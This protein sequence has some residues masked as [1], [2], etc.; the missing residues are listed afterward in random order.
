MCLPVPLPARSASML[1]PHGMRPCDMHARADTPSDYPH[2]L[3]IDV[4]RMGPKG[5]AAV[6]AS[7]CC[8]VLPV[9]TESSPLV[10]VQ[11]LLPLGITS[12][13]LI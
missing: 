11:Q 10:S 8:S 2:A 1:R 9:S 12:T 6:F 5:Q 3:L 4:S 7:H 13:N